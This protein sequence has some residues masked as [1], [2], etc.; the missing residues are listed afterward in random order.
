MNKQEFVTKVD[1]QGLMSRHFVSKGRDAG[2]QAIYN[3]GLAKG[4]TED[5][6]AKW[7]AKAWDKLEEEV[8]KADAAAEVKPEDTKPKEPKKIKVYPKETAKAIT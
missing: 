6:K 8:Q 3:D 7:A 2:I 4:D 1:G 5:D